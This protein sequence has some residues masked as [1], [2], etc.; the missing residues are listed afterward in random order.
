MR[1]AV[2]KLSGNI[3]LIGL[4]EERSLKSFRQQD[5]VFCNK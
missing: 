5:G 1:D 3:H 2:E 4:N